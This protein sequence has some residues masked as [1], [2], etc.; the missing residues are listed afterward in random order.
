MLAAE[1]DS[2][3][4]RSNSN[5]VSSYYCLKLQKKIQ[6]QGTFYN[7]FNRVTRQLCV[8]CFVTKSLANQEQKTL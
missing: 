2:I 4:D 1:M 7:I 6:L 3:S 5:N 8:K